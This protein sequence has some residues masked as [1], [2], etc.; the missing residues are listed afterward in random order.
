MSKA[1]GLNG[2]RL[3]VQAIMQ[4]LR[5]KAD[6]DKM[7]TSVNGQTGAVEMDGLPAVTASDAG[8]FLRVSDDGEWEAEDVP[9]AEGASF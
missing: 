9:H 4:M 2:L 3:T 8:K 6:K 1:T 5:K 7:V